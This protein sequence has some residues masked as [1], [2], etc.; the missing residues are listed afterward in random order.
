MTTYA[1]PEWAADGENCHGLHLEVI[2]SGVVLDTIM[3]DS[4]SFFVAGRMEPLCDLVLQHPSVSRTHAALQ[5]NAQ[6]KLF[7]VDLKS[8]HGT[9]V[10]KRRLPPSEYT[11]LHVGDV[12]VFGES[13]RFYTILGPQELMPDEYNSTNLENLRA[14]LEEKRATKEKADKACEGI[15][16]G[17]GED[18]EEDDN[19]DQESDDDV[20]TTAKPKP[21][22]RADTRGDLPD[23][24]RD[25][26]DGG[27]PYVSSVSKDSISEKDKA[28]YTRLQARM[29]KLENLR[30]ECSRIRAKESG[31]LTDGQQAALDKNDARMQQLQT[32]IETIEAT[33]HSK[34]L[35]RSTQKAQADAKAQA[36]LAKGKAKKT[37]TVYDSDDDDFYDRT[38]AHAKKHVPLAQAPRVLTADS[39]RANLRALQHQYDTIQAQYLKNE[40]QRYHTG[41]NCTEA[42]LRTTA[43][44][45][46][47]DSLDAYLLASNSALQADQRVKLEAEKARLQGLIDEQNKL[48]AIATPALD[49]VVEKASVVPFEVVLEP[50]TVLATAVPAT[51]SPVADKAVSPEPVRPSPPPKLRSP[52]PPQESRSESPMVAPVALPPKRGAMPLNDPAKKRVK[53]AGKLGPA[54]VYDD[55][56]LEGG[57]VVWQPPA[58]QTG[59]G[60]TALN[61]KYGY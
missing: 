13:T 7:V 35:Q 3:L 23:Y 31:G 5:F 21:K 40:S 34:Q 26:K 53:S 52:S 56:V 47:E 54:K 29:Q 45:D 38:S 51:L 11:E 37:T 50:A 41:D 2:K 27:G 20:L 61:D 59:D 10:N 43:P 39:I 14:E 60:R 16:W 28:L 48:L 12:V 1:P 24:L 49:K 55:A 4:K 18:A 42:D 57:D 6:G 33:L 46:E 36:A 25:R 44:T 22:A 32:E 19:S 30:S 15:S 17:F 9:R 8:T 58:N